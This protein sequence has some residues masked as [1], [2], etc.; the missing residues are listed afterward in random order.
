MK[1]SKLLLSYITKV[2]FAGLIIAFLC[3]A[4]FFIFNKNNY[5]IDIK[6]IYNGKSKDTILELWHIETF[7]GGSVNRAKFL[8]NLAVNFNKQNQGCF[9]VIKALSVEQAQLN[10]EKGFLPDMVSFGVGSG[11]LFAKYL[12]PIKQSYDIRHDILDYGK[13]N[14]KVYAVPYMLGGYV[15]ITNLDQ[16]VDTSKLDN[17]LANAFEMTRVGGKHKTPSLCFAK[18]TNIN[19]AQSLIHKNIKSNNSG[20]LNNEFSTYQAYEQFI[21]NQCVS[22]IGTQR[23]LVRCVLRE[24]NGNIS[25]CVYTPID[26]YNDLI[27][28]M[29]VINSDDA[30]KIN[31]ANKFLNFVLDKDVQQKIK[32]ISMFSVLQTP[33]YSSEDGAIFELEK[34]VLKQITSVNVFTSNQVLQQNKAKSW[35]NLGI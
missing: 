6:N 11:E 24:Q 34:A 3:I 4:P 35:A 33:I 30:N 7:E 9:F 15:M 28:Y 1:K 13:M 19:I 5:I 18:N 21:K 32:N 27:Q 17:L 12:S 14:S 23:D 29:G 22:L 10:I 25:P 8:Q 31:I 26:G 20:F 16:V 2:I